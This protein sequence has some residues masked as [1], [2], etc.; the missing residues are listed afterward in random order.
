MLLNSTK[1]HVYSFANV[2]EL[3]RE[4]QQRGKITP[5]QTR[6]KIKVFWIKDYEV[7]IFIR[8]VTNK[9]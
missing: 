6:I 4:I 5:T 8:D 3:L 7:I 2:S 9:I 1:C